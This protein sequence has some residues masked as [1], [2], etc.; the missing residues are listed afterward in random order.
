M[1]DLE[2]DEIFVLL[3]GS[4]TLSVP[5]QTP[6]YPETE[7]KRSTLARRDDGAYVLCTYFRE[8]WAGHGWSVEQTEEVV[9]DR[10][11]LRARLTYEARAAFVPVSG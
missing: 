9:L 1:T 4:A 2:A 7:A 6:L 10:A 5:L 11:A 8:F 3:E